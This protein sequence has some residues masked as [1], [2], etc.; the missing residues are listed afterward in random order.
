MWGWQ[1]GHRISQDYSRGKRFEE[2]DGIQTDI[3]YKRKG[4][5][6]NSCVTAAHMNDLETKALTEK[7]QEKVQICKNKT[8]G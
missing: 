7:Q 4:H 8:T 6:L 5:V 3:A 2:R 1:S